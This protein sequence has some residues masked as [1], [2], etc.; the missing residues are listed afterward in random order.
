MNRPAVRLIQSRANFDLLLANV[1]SPRPSSV[2]ALVSDAL[3][4]EFRKL[5]GAWAR[6]A[7]GLLPSLRYPTVEFIGTTRDLRLR[8][9]GRLA[10]GVRILSQVCNPTAGE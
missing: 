1:F 10:K 9:F 3:S 8:N 7:R 6:D 5:L 2:Y 4:I